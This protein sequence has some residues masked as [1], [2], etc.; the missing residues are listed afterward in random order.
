MTPL[1]WDASEYARPAQASS[2]A[3]T[4]TGRGV[5]IAVIDSGVHAAH[6]H[7]GGVAGGIAFSTDGRAHEDFVDR[8]G[9]GTAVIA[10][11]KEK[12]P[13]AEIYAVKV[14]DR[15]LATS[16]ITLVRAIDWA[17]AHHMHVVNLSLG[18]PNPAH[19]EVM[20]DAARRADFSDVRIVSAHPA[21][22]QR[23]LPGALPGVVGVDVDWDCPRDHYALID[24][25]PTVAFRASGYPRD[26]PGVSREQNLKGVSFAVANMTGF[27]AR[28]LQGS[29]AVTFHELVTRLR[30]AALPAQA[31]SEH[32]V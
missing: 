21:G 2:A 28:A 4:A 3:S 25:E 20:R 19:D 1:S 26:I 30:S 11:I 23:W 24:A 14:F 18:T 8:L 9:H 16:V 17:I 12:A 7:V 10:A 5:R 22:T 31:D 15:A 32:A 13:D 6:P 27:V 29:P